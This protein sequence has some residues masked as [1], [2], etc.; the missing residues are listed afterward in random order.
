[1]NPT[2]SSPASLCRGTTSGLWATARTRWCTCCTSLPAA[3]SSWC[4]RVPSL[5]THLTP[6]HAPGRSPI[7]RG[8]G[9]RC[10]L[11][12]LNLCVSWLD[13][14][15][16]APQPPA[17]KWV[18]AS[19]HPQLA[20]IYDQAKSGML[21]GTYIPV[22]MYSCGAHTAGPMLSHRPTFAAALA[23]AQA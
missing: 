8:C 20:E 1:M 5:F 17:S 18:A 3:F 9:I 2:S 15:S 21:E 19:P 12:L 4:I 13:G 10:G 11:L 6:E 14:G 23:G 16:I 7:K 22:A